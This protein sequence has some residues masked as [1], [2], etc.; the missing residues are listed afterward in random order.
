MPESSLAYVPP[1]V[2]D[3][4]HHTPRP[5]PRRA[6]SRALGAYVGVSRAGAV[7]LYL[8]AGLLVSVA[9]AWTC[10]ARSDL[11]PPTSALPEP[12]MQE[13]VFGRHVSSDTCEQRNGVGVQIKAAATDLLPEI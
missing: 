6:R 5:I 13:P 2:M 9:I 8:I 11:G 4:R 3:L 10:A 1:L 12:W 7:T